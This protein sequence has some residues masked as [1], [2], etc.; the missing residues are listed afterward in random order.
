MT[1]RIR[2]NA[3]SHRAS[4]VVLLL[5]LVLLVVLSTLVYTVSTRVFAQRQRMN[6]MIHYA[7]ARYACDSALKCFEASFTNLAPELIARPN[8]PDFSDLFAYDE[9]Q[10]QAFLQDWLDDET[11]Q[12]S[13]KHMTALQDANTAD[14]NQIGAPDDTFLAD[15][16]TPDQIR[17]RGPYEPNW[18]WIQAP[19]VIDI[20]DRT[21]VTIEISDENAKY[22]RAWMVMD[23]EKLTRQITAGFEGL[24]EWM[25]FGLSEI[26]EVKAQ[27]DEIV[28]IKPFKMDF[29][30]ITKVEKQPAARRIPST[31][32]SRRRT[33]STRPQTVRRVPKR[34]TIS[35]QQQKTEQDTDFVRLLSSSLLDVDMLARP[36]LL[37]DSRRNE[38]AL[39]Y[40]GRYGT[41]RVNVNTAPRHVLEA[42]FAFCGGDAVDIADLVIQRRRMQPIADF[43]DLK[44]IAFSYADS[45]ENCEKF[46][47][48]ASTV[49]SVK[50]TATSGVPLGNKVL[51]VAQATKILV[52][53]KSGDKIKKLALISG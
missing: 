44:K 19:I 31:T 32:A 1:R 45:I 21:Q 24:M 8:E 7:K 17:V 48:T 25:D 27:L 28:A 35:A 15:A 43:A 2:I 30:P 23:D 40:I 51:G 18:P 34:T 14:A 26:D 53:T 50:V 42:A 22:P 46:I 16:L 11:A 37:S 41:M 12:L 29:K 52:V 38:S 4:G 47:V 36:T 13:Y 10:Y 33:P 20:D 3:R 39:K 6:Y 5:T 49:F 9:E